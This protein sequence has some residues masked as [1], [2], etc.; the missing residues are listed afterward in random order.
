[1]GK[2]KMSVLKSADCAV[3]ATCRKEKFGDENVR[4]ESQS[5]QT[6]MSVNEE[7][8]ERGGRREGGERHHA[9]SIMCW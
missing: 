1:M 9:D 6:E 3:S 5:A 2:T 7:D 8:V 4:G